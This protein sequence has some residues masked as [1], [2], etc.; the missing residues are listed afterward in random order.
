M[1]PRMIYHI[2]HVGNWLIF[3]GEVSETDRD[4][5]AGAIFNIENDFMLRERGKNHLDLTA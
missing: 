3:Q 2:H 1:G 5:K 4:K